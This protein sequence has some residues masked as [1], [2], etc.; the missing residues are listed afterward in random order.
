LY[1]SPFYVAV[2]HGK[3]SVILSIRGTLS[4]QNILTD[5]IV[6]PEKIPCSRSQMGDEWFAHK[7]MLRTAMSLKNILET[8][9]ILTE[10]FNKCPAN[11]RSNYQLIIVGHS[12]GAGAAAILAILLRETYPNLF[13][14]AYSP[15]GATLSHDATK[16]AEDFILSVVIGKDMIA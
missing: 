11:E 4:L 14:Y 8:K 2:D 15:P 7:G 9:N 13:C 6:E 16:Y 12:L 1:V 5:L 10:A 3:K